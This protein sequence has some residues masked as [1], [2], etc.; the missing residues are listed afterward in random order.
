MKLPKGRLDQEDRQNLKELPFKVDIIINNRVQTYRIPYKVLK[1]L[2]SAWDK[3]KYAKGSK[4][5][6][7]LKKANMAP[8]EL[9]KYYRNRKDWSQV[10]LAK[11]INTSQAAISQIENGTR[12]IGIDVAKALAEIFGKHVNYRN[13]L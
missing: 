13:F 5:I 6:K 9:V 7:P 10:D 8:S 2:L 12:N 3:R 1:P 11:A 4:P